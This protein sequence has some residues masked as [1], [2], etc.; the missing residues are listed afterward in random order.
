MRHAFRN[1]GTLINVVITP[2]AVM[3]LFLFVMGGVS[4][5]LSGG[6]INF[7]VP[8]IV[9]MCLANGVA[10]TALRLNND[11]TKGIINRF[12]CMPIAPSSILAGH[13]VTSIIANLF[14]VA[15]II[16]VALLFGFNP[17]AGA[18]S[19]LIFGTVILL[20]TTAT[21]WLA[22]IFGLISK[23]AESAGAFSYLLI[24][25]TFVSSAFTPINSMNKFVKIFAEHQPITSIIETLRSLIINNE[26]GA[27]IWIAIV[28]CVGLLL[29]SNVIALQIYRKRTFSN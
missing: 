16:I 1:I 12:R 29:V 26:V 18:I 9:L 17:K 6:Y 13:V 20:F 8:G 22:I 19:W 11:V 7:I 15:L 21:T 28:W 5:T 27:N 25:L 2:I 3:L 23:T 24:L 10:F 4:T 14:S